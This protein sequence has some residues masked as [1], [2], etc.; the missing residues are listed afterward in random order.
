MQSAAQRQLSE[1]ELRRLAL[2]VY[3][4]KQSEAQSTAAKAAKEAEAIKAAE[5]RSLKIQLLVCIAAL[6]VLIMGYMFI[7]TQVT[8]IGYEINKQ[9]K[10]NDELQN[11]NNRLVLQIEQ[12]TSPEK[13]AT[14]AAE[15][16]NMVSPTE[17][18]VIYYDTTNWQTESAPVVRTGM[19]VDAKSIGY[20]TLELVDDD[21]SGG[22]LGM[23][24]SLI[25]QITADDTVSLGMRN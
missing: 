6:F 10:L 9:V 5:A 17:E 2:R 11:E 8:M 15:H 23:L 20:G 18:T 14:F 22:L 21:E 7:N 16:F 25:E 19:A 3:D 4:G 12:A 24:G 13:V 1:A